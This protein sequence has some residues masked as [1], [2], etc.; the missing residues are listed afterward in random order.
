MTEE[1]SGGSSKYVNL[2]KGI[3]QKWNNFEKR[4]IFIAKIILF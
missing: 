3:H 1:G 4:S 2:S